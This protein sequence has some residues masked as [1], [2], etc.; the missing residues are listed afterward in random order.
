[1]TSSISSEIYLKFSEDLNAT[2]PL[3]LHSFF[4]LCKLPIPFDLFILTH[5][6]ASIARVYLGMS[7]IKL[8]PQFLTHP[9][10][11]LSSDLD[12]VGH[13]GVCGIHP[14]NFCLQYIQRVEVILTYHE[15]DTF[16]VQ[17]CVQ[18]EHI[19]NYNL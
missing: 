6:D 17:D 3:Q 16:V 4:F 2:I 1:M 8:L 15:P 19:L 5:R 11:C 12:A 9:N 14:H 13:I 10:A 7:Y 18:M